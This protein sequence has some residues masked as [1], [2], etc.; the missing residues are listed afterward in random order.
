ME[1][2]LDYFIKRCKL[3]LTQEQKELFRSI[4]DNANKEI[5]KVGELHTVH[6]QDLN[7][8]IDELRQGQEYWQDSAEKWRE[9]LDSAERKIVALERKITSL[10]KEKSTV[11]RFMNYWKNLFEKF[12]KEKGYK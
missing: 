8:R 11:I 10:R 4:V 7:N 6:L 1:F 5:V 9:G 2:K 12:S 3:R